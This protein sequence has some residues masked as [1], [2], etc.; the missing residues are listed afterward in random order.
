LLSWPDFFHSDKSGKRHKTLQ[1][2]DNQ[3]MPKKSFKENNPALR[4]ISTHKEPIVHDVQSEHQEQN[5]QYEQSVQVG[6]NPRINMAFK[7]GNLEYLQII[8]RV[9]GVSI[10]EYVNRLIKQD[11]EQQW[12]IIQ[13]A[14]KLL[15]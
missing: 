14:R 10:T 8:S 9:E 11:S 3:K 12:D 1:Q 7:D 4:F 5:A 6:K 2:E 13:T 15:K